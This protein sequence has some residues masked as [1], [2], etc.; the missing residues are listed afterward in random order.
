MAAAKPIRLP[1]RSAAGVSR[2]VRS[3]GATGP[4][5][6]SYQLALLFCPLAWVRCS[7]VMNS[8]QGKLLESTWSQAVSPAV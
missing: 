5:T 8:P 1:C 2:P 4:V 7:P 6:P 3:R